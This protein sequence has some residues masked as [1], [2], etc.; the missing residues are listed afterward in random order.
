MSGDAQ[1]SEDV[2]SPG[3]T[4]GPPPRDAGLDSPASRDACNAPALTLP[5]P[6]AA[7]GYTVSTFSSTFDKARVDLANSQVSGFQWYLS[8]FSNSH[9][10]PSALTFESCSGVSLNAA[11]LL[12]ATPAAPGNDVHNWVGVAFGGGAYFEATLSFDP[13]NTINAPS[14]AGWPAWWGEP[15]EHFAILPSE[16]WPGQASGYIHYVETDF[17]EYNIWSWTPHYE[18]SGSMLDWYGIWQ[19]TACPSFCNV[20]NSGGPDTNYNNREVQAP[21]TTDYTKLHQF[22]FLWIPATATTDGSAQFFFDRVA[23]N[24]KVT[25][26]KYTGSETPPPGKTPWTF[27][28]LDQQHMVLTVNTGVGQPMTLQSVAVWQAS[29]AHNLTQ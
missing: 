7:A 1:L 17:F 19:S 4:G 11:G 18:Y 13:E 24:D 10:D 9:T 20:Q 3:D 2:S 28:V 14:G 8:N 12:S 25:W 16:Q 15:I 6:A 21:A 23:T 5:A 26:S 22:G 29:A 27:G